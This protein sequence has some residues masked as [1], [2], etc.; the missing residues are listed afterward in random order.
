VAV[1]YLTKW[2][3]A[4]ATSKVDAKTLIKFLKRNI[5]NIFDTSIIFLSDGGS[6]F[7][8]TA[9]KSIRTLKCEA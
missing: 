4:I 6:H 2:V 9:E 8:N 3:E 5:F 7:R 1:N